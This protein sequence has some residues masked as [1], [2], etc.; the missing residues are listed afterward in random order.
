MGQ[1][2][3]VFPCSIESRTTMRRELTTDLGAGDVTV[4]A[5][6]VAG[7]GERRPS[8]FTISLEQAVS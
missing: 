7:A 6:V 8:V 5:G 2:A 1:D 4:S 3:V